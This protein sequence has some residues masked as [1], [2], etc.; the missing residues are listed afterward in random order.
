MFGQVNERN[1]RIS[2][3]IQTAFAVPETAIQLNASGTGSLSASFSC[4]RDGQPLVITVSPAADGAASQMT[5]AT[6]SIEAAGEVVQDLAGYLNV[7]SLQSVANF[8]TEMAAL[9][10]VLQK[11]DQYNQTRLTLAAEMADSSNLIKTLVIKAEVTLP[12]LVCAR[13]RS[14][15][16]V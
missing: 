5:V 3:W 1:Q 15:Q 9:K 13:T 10:E 7:T 6:D 16:L 11:V 14:Q 4:L 12:R 8:P 2:M